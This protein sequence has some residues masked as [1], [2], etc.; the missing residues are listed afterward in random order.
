M[1]SKVFKILYENW[2]EFVSGEYIGKSLG[3]SRAAVSKA[4]SELKD[5]GLEILS[6]SKNGHKLV[7]LN[8]CLDADILSAMTGKKTLFFEECQSTNLEARKLDGQAELVAAGRQS[9]GRGRRGRNFSSNFGGV[10]MS[11]IIKPRFSPSQTML[12]NLAAGLSV[13]DVLKDLGFEPYLKYPNDIY[14]RGKKVCGI[15]T[16]TLADWDTLQWAIVGI[17]INVNNDLPEDLQDIA[18]SMSKEKGRKYDRAK[19]IA[20]VIKNFNCYISQDI[21]THYKSKCSMLGSEIAIIND[22]TS[23]TARAIDITKDGLLVV[24]RQGKN[25]IAVGGEVSVNIK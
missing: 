22:Q 6:V 17:G 2:G 7:S 14:I 5:K 13:Y 25:E 20:D 24:D 12:I 3:V 4:I 19:I 11:Y 21:V 15:L 1:T 8:D 16:E 23:Y 9:Q 18:T 10:Y